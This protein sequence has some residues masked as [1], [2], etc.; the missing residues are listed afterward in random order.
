[1]LNISTKNA[2]RSEIRSA[3]VISQTGSWAGCNSALMN[4]SPLM[5]GSGLFCDR[6]EIADLEQADGAVARRCRATPRKCNWTGVPAATSARRRCRRGRLP[7]GARATCRAPPGTRLRSDSPAAGAPSPAR[8][9]PTNSRLPASARRCS[10]RT[11]MSRNGDAQ[12]AALADIIGIGERNRGCD[13]SAPYRAGSPASA[14]R[15][16]ARPAPS[17]RCRTRRWD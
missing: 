2:S 1:M 16:A 9:A 3:K 6:R 13:L 12:P 15:R 5:T 8:S 4:S 7:R 11:R 10:R 14:H 17:G